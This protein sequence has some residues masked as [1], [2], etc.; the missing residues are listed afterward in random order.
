MASV[1]VISLTRFHFFTLGLGLNDAFDTTVF[2]AWSNAMIRRHFPEIAPIHHAIPLPGYLKY[3]SQKT[4]NRVWLEAQAT[5]MF[6]S[7]AARRQNNPNIVLAASTNGYEAF[8]ATPNAFHITDHG[9]LDPRYERRVLEEEGRRFGFAVAGNEK[10]SWRYPLIDRDLEAC[11]RLNLCSNFAAKTFQEGGFPADKIFVNSFGV[12]T[13]K[14][15]PLPAEERAMRRSD[16]IRIIYVGASIPR[17]G[18]HRLIRA[19]VDAG[20]LRFT[21]TCVGAGPTDPVLQK[22]FDEGRAAG[23]T[24]TSVPPVL[25]STLVNHYHEADVF[26]LPSIADGWGLVTNQAMACGLFCLV[27]KYAGS[28]DIVTPETGQVF[29][30]Y[31]HDAFVAMLQGLVLDELHAKAAASADGPKAQ[32]WGAFTQRGRDDL[33]RQLGEADAA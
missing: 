32:D 25:E 29:D 14:F 13:S 11:D 31:D 22:I 26:C 6:S 9:S 30:P 12:E 10:H 3:L 19:L 17:K 2:S 21:L 24:V 27:S 15:Y 20:P 1:S 4:V 8:K 33:A 23:L 7:A 28:A 18:L 16:K 5:S